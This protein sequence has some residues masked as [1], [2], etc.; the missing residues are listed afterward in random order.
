MNSMI[1]CSCWFQRNWSWCK[2]TLSNTPGRSWEKIY[3]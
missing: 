3:I 2:R 1:N